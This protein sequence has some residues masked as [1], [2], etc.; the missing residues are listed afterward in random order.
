[1][2]GCRVPLRRQERKYDAS[3]L[4]PRRVW[5]GDRVS[6]SRLPLDCPRRARVVRLDERRAPARLPHY[7]EHFVV[8]YMTEAL[9]VFCANPP[10]WRSPS[11]K[12]WLGSG[13]IEPGDFDGAS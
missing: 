2:P 11:R 5:A 12:R 8:G 7:F 13:P 4:L 3:W 6:T 1:R 9:E 10:R